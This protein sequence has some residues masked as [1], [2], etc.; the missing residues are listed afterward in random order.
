MII[1]FSLVFFKYFLHGLICTAT[2]DIF[3]ALYLIDIHQLIKRTL[4]NHQLTIA[5]MT[6]LSCTVR[7]VLRQIVGQ[8]MD[9]VIAQVASVQ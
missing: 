5:K 1:R 3:W 7:P 8:Y 4:V 9:A 6:G 2:S